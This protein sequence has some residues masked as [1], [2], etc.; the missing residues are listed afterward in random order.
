[1][2]GFTLMNLLSVGDSKIGGTGDTAGISPVGFQP[3]LQRWFCDNSN[4]RPTEK[5]SRI[6]V[7]GI[8][9]ATYAARVGSDI[10]AMTATPDEILINLGANDTIATAGDKN[11]WRGNMEYIADA[12]HT[13]FPSA[14]IRLTKVWKRN[15]AITIGYISDAIDEMYLSRSWLKTGIDERAFLPSTDD[16]ATYTT[17][18]I[19]PN[20]AG[21][22]LMATAWHTAMGYA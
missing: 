3:I 6:G 20:H 11:I 2:S 9:A 5:P 21:Y 4:V 12:Y 8:N 18:G 7:G 15:A 16:G 22:I 13:A 14:N 19:H 1:M 17:D 10:A